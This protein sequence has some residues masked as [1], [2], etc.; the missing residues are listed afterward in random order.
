M[1]HQT[2]RHQQHAF[3]L[4]G[5]KDAGHQKMTSVQEATL[6]ITALEGRQTCNT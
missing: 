4:K 2:R 3:S 6:P 5:A 1:M